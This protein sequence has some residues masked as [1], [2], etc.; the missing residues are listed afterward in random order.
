[1][2]LA[3]KKLLHGVVMSLVTV[4]PAAAADWA[5]LYAGATAGY[6]AGSSKASTTTIFS[7][8]GYFA[9]S[10]I[11][12]IAAAGDQKISVHGYALG[13]EVGYNW[14]LGSGV[15]GI[16]ADLGYFGMKGDNEA[17]GT[18][19]CCLPTGFTVKSEARTDWLL[20][21]R[22]RYGWA[23][24]N[25]FYYV[26]AG[27]AVTKLE[28]KF[29]FTDTFASATESGTASKTKAGWVVGGGA[30][31]AMKDPWSLKLEYLYADFGEVSTTSDNFAAFG[32]IPFPTNV[33]THTLDLEVSIL[34]IGLNYRF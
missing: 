16:E 32:T 14:R 2:K 31:Y 1:M 13:G 19:P 10:S 20:T 30:E 33:F 22:P 8:T 25:W 4:A 21:V 3:S 26:T 11:A 34:R 23:S 18:Y 15:L 5:G 12:P 7:L 29:T 17:S 27:L 28:G 24:D 6:G 9:A